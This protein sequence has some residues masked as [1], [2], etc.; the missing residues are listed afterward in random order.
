MKLLF[1]QENGLNESLGVAILSSAVKSSAHQCDLILVSHSK[2]IYKDIRDKQPDLLG[3]SC[4]T[5]SHK[6]LLTLIK[7]IK[8][9]FPCIPNI[10]GGPH[11]TFYPEV[12]EN[13]GLDMICIGEGEGA[14][15][16]LMNGLSK[17]SDITKIPNLHIKRGGLILKND[18]RPLLQDLDALPLPDRGIYYKYEFLRDVSMKRF[19]TSRG[20]PFQ[21]SFCHNSALMRLYKDKGKYLRRHSVNRIIQE[22]KF[23]KEKYP[24]RSVHFSDDNIA[25]DKEW[26]R[27]FSKEFPKEIGLSFTCSMRFDHITLEVADYLKK[28]GCFGVALGLESGSE[29][30]RNELLKKGLSNKEIIEKACILRQKNIRILTTNIVGSPTETMEDVYDTVELN[31]HIKANFARIFALQAFP[32]L[33][34]TQIAIDK[35]LLPGDYNVEDCD[36]GRREITINNNIKKEMEAIIACFYIAVK[37]PFLWPFLKKVIKLPIRVCLKPLEL[38]YIYQ[39]MEFF[40]VSYLSGSKFFINTIGGIRGFLFGRRKA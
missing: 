8:R 12:L 24:L 35:C 9:K 5:G 29:R 23:I 18:L 34:I 26:L 14:L 13:E 33:E 36:S 40:Q 37:Y 16:D 38:F 21:C 27:E 6:S 39:E 19:I 4:M 20:C 1:I 17:K 7:V 10:L 3:F 25:L 30:I 11:P 31:Q 22:V 32:R 2:D 15:C 28:A